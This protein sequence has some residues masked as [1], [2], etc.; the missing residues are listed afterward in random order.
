MLEG[1]HIVFGASSGIGEAIAQRLIE[2]G[3]TVS[4]LARRAER[5][6]TL[7][8]AGATAFPA[9]VTDFE[10]TKQALEQAVA[11]HGPARSFVYCAGFQLIKP[12]RMSKAEEVRQVVDVNLTAPLLLAGLF[13]SK[14]FTSTD[15][16]FCTVS[17]IAAT[18]AEAGIVAYGATKAGMDGMVRGL[19]REVGPRRVVGVAPG[20]LDTE[21]T[22]RSSHIYNDK[23][24]EELAK[25]SPAGPASVEN[26][27]DTVEFLLS[28][29]AAAITG[30]II[31]V[32]GG[33]AA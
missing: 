13:A 23:F 33:A 2:R 14:K 3:G 11:Q 32:D 24:R 17:S 21:M 15:A 31:R 22:Q 6:E 1:H 9:D 30:E 20:W 8:A 4:A 5:L 7:A 29:A 18:R 19:A 27:V 26:V 16:V 12:V 25:M 10:G 28:P